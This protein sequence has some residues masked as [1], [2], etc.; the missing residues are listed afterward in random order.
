MVYPGKWFA[1]ASVEETHVL[2]NLERS[3]IENREVVLYST[4]HNDAAIVIVLMISINSRM[5]VSNFS[6]YETW[7]H[8]VVLRKWQ[9]LKNV[10]RPCRTP[11]C[12]LTSKSLFT[13]CSKAYGKNNKKLQKRLLKRLKE[14]G[15]RQQN[16][17]NR[18]SRDHNLK[19]MVG[20]SY[21]K[22]ILKYPHTAPEKRVPQKRV[23]HIMMTYN[24]RNKEQADS[25]DT[26]RHASTNV[27][28]K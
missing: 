16:R 8:L 7:T 19:T 23:H 12:M 10:F 5:G 6:G 25:N 9:N 20:R 2:F 1:S 15:P 4:P 11:S 3:F 14:K 26:S 27:G 21:S 18:S 17:L 13:H 22:S 28:S 24:Q